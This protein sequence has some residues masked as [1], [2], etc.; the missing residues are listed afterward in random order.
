MTDR[1]APNYAV[2]KSNYPSNYNDGP[3]TSHGLGRSGLDSAV[4]TVRTPDSP[5]D[6]RLPTRPHGYV[7]SGVYTCRGG[8]ASTLPEHHTRPVKC[9]ECKKPHLTERA[10]KRCQRAYELKKKRNNS[11]QDQL[12]AR[13]LGRLGISD[14][15]EAEEESSDEEADTENILEDQQVVEA[16]QQQCEEPELRPTPVDEPR[17]VIH[18]PEELHLPPMEEA[19]EFAITAVDYVTA[20]EVTEPAVACLATTLPEIRLQSMA[21][22]VCSE[23]KRPYG[24][25]LAKTASRWHSHIVMLCTQ[26]TTRL[27]AALCSEYRDH[28]HYG[29]VIWHHTAISILHVALGAFNKATNPNSFGTR[30]VSATAARVIWSHDH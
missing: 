19:E 23:G 15:T 8:T 4:S 9:A 10:A 20:V 27:H 17:V 24:Q 12:R 13:L 1:T 29:S 25:W 11:F 22:S 26:A 3:S 7:A 6:S 14:A 28:R 21:V 30:N 16:E 5:V 18:H 2:Q